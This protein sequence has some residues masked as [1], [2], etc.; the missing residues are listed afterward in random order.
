MSTVAT[1]IRLGASG[2]MGT[3]RRLF[4]PTAYTA[5][6]CMGIAKIDNCKCF[7]IMADPSP[8]AICFTTVDT[9]IYIAICDVGSLI[10]FTKVTI[11]KNKT[12]FACEST[13]I[14]VNIA[15]DAKIAKAGTNSHT[16]LNMAAIYAN[17]RIGACSEMLG[18]FF[19]H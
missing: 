18:A 4:V 11:V 16:F 17:I 7:G 13:V 2:R 15:V 10:N 6:V 1:C 19:A 3:D 5:K 12:I 9:V 8:V 14:F